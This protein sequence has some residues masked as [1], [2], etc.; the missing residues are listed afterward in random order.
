MNFKLFCFCFLQIGFI[1]KQYRKTRSYR[2]KSPSTFFT[3]MQ[4]EEACFSSTPW[5]EPIKINYHPAKYGSH[6][7]SESGDVFSLSRDLA[8]SRDQRVI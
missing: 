6:R 8:R 7:H 1:L 2:L 5:L 4:D 3:L